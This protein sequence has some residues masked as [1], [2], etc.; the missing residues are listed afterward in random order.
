MFHSECCC[1]SQAR[2]RHR[3]R[4]L[5][6]IED[7]KRWRCDERGKG[8]GPTVTATATKHWAQTNVRQSVLNPERKT[9]ERWSH[10]VH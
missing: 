10:N 5:D 2:E 1:R 9:G 7:W 3:I 8:R 4:R 6:A